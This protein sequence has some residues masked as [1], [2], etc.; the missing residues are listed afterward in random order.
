MPVAT[1]G[2][3]VFR[4]HYLAVLCSLF[5]FALVASPAAAQS[6]NSQTCVTNFSANTDYFPSKIKVENATFFS[7]QYFNNYKLVTNKNTNE[8]FALTQCGT[9]QPT[10]LP[11]G[12]KYFTVPVKHVA[13][14]YT[15]DVTFLEF[16][17][18]RSAITVL[19]SSV[20]VSSPCAQKLLANNTIASLSQ[21]ATMATEQEASV[22]V[23]FGAFT[24]EPAQNNSVSI[25][26]TSDPGTL[27][28]AE[29]L[30]F[31]STFFNL[32]DHAQSIT[33][34]LFDNYNC[35]RDASAA[36]ASATRP[37]VAWTSYDA[38][39]DYN[40]KT[41]SWLISVAPY[42][43]QLTSDAGATIFNSTTL[44]FSTSAAFLDAV[45]NVDI[46]ID[47]TYISSNI[48]DVYK[49]YNITTDNV[50]N[51]KFASSKRI[52]REDTVQT[53]AG[54]IDWFESAVV[55]EDAVL[56]DLINVVN[57]S[58][59]SASY[60]RV[61]LRNVAQGENVVIKTAADCVDPTAPVV[62]IAPKC[63]G[64][65][66]TPVNGTAPSAAAGNKVN[67]LWSVGMAVVVVVVAT[68]AM[69]V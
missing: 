59:P 21:N 68:V 34:A 30:K 44:T 17:G 51:L 69:W 38:P 10:N 3:S 12:T 28:R 65:F 64:T 29:W 7:V 18:V 53:L 39:S 36:A 60:K 45:A 19:G 8:T 56:A 2:M 4:T 61:W 16:L 57:S 32:E 52:F 27:N 33:Q 63:N 14:V 22:D 31:Y 67:G 50:G 5:A 35:L 55:Q 58:Y 20:D 62:D 15:T 13:A 42:K 47:E 40:N 9:P 43:A 24:A 11:N 26:S 48:T 46:L 1:Y 6:A 37:V 25:S 54:A 41:A 66:V 23:V 49:N